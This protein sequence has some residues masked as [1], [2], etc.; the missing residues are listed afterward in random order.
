[1]DMTPDEVESGGMKAVLR[2][3]VGWSGDHRVVSFAFPPPLSI[4][5][6]QILREGQS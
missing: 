3:P 5:Y 6:G 4:R 1:M 2:V